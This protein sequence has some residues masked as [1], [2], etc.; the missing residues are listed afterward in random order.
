MGANRIEE[1]TA[2][3]RWIDAMLSLCVHLIG[4]KQQKRLGKWLYDFLIQTALYNV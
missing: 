3:D 1:D 4:L 2:E